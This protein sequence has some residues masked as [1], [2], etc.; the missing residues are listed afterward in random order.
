MNRELG[1]IQV[2]NVILSGLMVNALAFAVGVR[3]APPPAAV[4]AGHR[5][6]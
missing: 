2:A 4:P 5:G 1:W 3:R 6:S